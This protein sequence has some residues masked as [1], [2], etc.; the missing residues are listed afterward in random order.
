MG[1][2]NSFVAVG[3]N[4]SSAGSAMIFSEFIIKVS[5]SDS[6]KSSTKPKLC[7]HESPRLYLIEVN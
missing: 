6:A 5:T 3:N 1:E 7:W 4:E 2:V